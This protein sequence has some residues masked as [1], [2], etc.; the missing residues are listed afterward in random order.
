MMVEVAE[1]SE[2]AVDPSLLLPAGAAL[3]VIAT[4]LEG[5]G[6]GNLT[7]QA[8]ALL[9]AASAVAAW[10]LIVRRGKDASSPL[11]VRFFSILAIALAISGLLAAAGGGWLGLVGVV[12][13]WIAVCG[14][15]LEWV[16]GRR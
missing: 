16:K 3:S 15:G 1:R 12:G 7:T 6:D 10:I 11:G 4:L 8:L 2:S 13:L 5:F 14:A 9:G